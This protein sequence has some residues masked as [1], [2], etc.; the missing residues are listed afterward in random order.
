MTREIKFRS[1]YLETNMVYS[2]NM[3]RE[4]QLG[5]F[6]EFYVDSHDIM[7]YTGFKDKNGKEIYDGDI[8]KYSDGSDVSHHKIFFDEKIGRWSDVRMEDQ[9]CQTTYDG[10]EFVGDCVVIG[11]IYENPDLIYEPK[12]IKRNVKRNIWGAEID[13]SID[14]TKNAGRRDEM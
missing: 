2:K 4:N 7:Q 6:F 1:W 8:L 3:V 13:D 12:K 11:N 10:F 14:F 5:A 9:D